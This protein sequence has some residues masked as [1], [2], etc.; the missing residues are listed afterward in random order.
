MC[1]AG[2][3]CEAVCGSWLGTIKPLSGV[4]YRAM[5]QS[6]MVE[7]LRDVVSME[8]P[9]ASVTTRERCPPLPPL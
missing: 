2:Q 4:L 6:C 7:V 8:S 9:P 5:L 3:G 1:E